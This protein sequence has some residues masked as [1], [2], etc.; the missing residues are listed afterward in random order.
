MCLWLSSTLA[1]CVLWSRLP[2]HRPPSYVLIR[3]DD[4]CSPLSP[5]PMA[6]MRYSEMPRDVS[7]DS[8]AT[9]RISD[10]CGSGSGGSLFQDKSPISEYGEPTS[11]YHNSSP[12]SENP[13]GT[14]GL[15]RRDS[16]QNGSSGN[17]LSARHR[18]GIS[19]TPSA[20]HAKRSLQ[21][22]MSDSKGACYDNYG[23][24]PSGS[25]ISPHSK[26]QSLPGH[27]SGA[28]V[29]GYDKVVLDALRVSPE[30]FAAQLT[31]LDLP[32]FRGIQPDE[33][34]SC[35]WNKKNKLV[36]APNVVAF[37]RRFNHVSFWTV[38]EILSGPTPKQRSEILVHFIRIAKK[39][40]E[41]NNL[42]SLFAII[43][44]LQS[45][46]VYRLNKTWGHLSKKEKQLFDKLAELFSDKNN[47]Q[48]LR[49]HMESLKLPCIPYLGLFLTDLVYIDM[50]HPHSGG[51]ESEQ[52]RLKMN[53]I[54]RIISDYQQSD[55]RNLVLLPHVQNY[56][57]SVRYI[58]ELQKFV[59]DDQYKLS[60][61]LE[62]PS[63][64]P[65]SSSSKESVTEAAAT[66]ASLNL[67]PAKGPGCAGSLRLHA[68]VNATGKFVPGHRK[69]RS[70]G[71][72]FRS[73]SLPRNLHKQ[74]QAT[75]LASMGMVA[76]GIFH[77][78][79]HAA[80]CG[81]VGLA[82]QLPAPSTP[83][84]LLDDSVLEEN[85][86]PSLGVDGTPKLPHPPSPIRRK[87]E[88]GV[89]LLTMFGSSLLAETDELGEECLVQGC[90]R[91]KTV[92][93][94]GRKPAVSS[95]QR[96]WVELW[97]SSLIYFSPKSFKGT[98]R[99]DFKHEPCKITAVSGMCVALG[100]NPVQP[101]VFQLADPVRG[102]VYKFR[103]GSK[104]T[105]IKWCRH[106]QE[107]TIGSP[108]K[109]LPANLMSF[110]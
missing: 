47:W 24:L 38:Q 104:S 106:L 25:N 88:D 85:S 103:S 75:L 12:S 96:Y 4:D 80:P 78:A 93:K 110:E 40:H 36:I 32:P 11:P 48:N 52:R 50:A 86:S 101:D 33:L 102:N 99:S 84:H 109:P 79:S 35:G 60:L 66:V 56:L 30:D 18:H 108:E 67:S 92:L 41:L 97:A 73:T 44:A 70:L 71:T 90:L 26:S 14:N 19:R 22:N 83:R 31:I 105:A 3:S 65:S 16:T 49:E 61:K 34:I 54:L 100:D 39:L 27:T 69:C 64:A 5:E 17:K 2:L 91:R 62:P 1:P 45:A 15:L 53:N 57:R 13:N 28:S 72:K 7:C 87:D 51:L 43:S 74:G 20:G 59:E 9:L 55:Y 10:N 107:L 46:S 58:E 29:C 6:K 42:H 21:S 82:S 81:D 68:A 37:T 94:D 23:S 63:P 98:E 89:K 77:K 95:W 76:P 8:L